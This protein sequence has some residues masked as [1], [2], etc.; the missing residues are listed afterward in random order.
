[1]Q[2]NF[3]IRRLRQVLGGQGHWGV[4]HNEIHCESTEVSKG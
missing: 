4:I 1:M 2:V 3:A